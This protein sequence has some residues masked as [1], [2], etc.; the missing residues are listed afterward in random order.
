MLDEF[1]GSSRR[2]TVLDGLP[3]SDGLILSKVIFSAQSRTMTEVGLTHRKDAV[4]GRA[5]QASH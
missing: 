4:W 3:V 2:M 5:A 1:F